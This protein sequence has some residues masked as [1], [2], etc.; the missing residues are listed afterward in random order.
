MTPSEPAIDLT[1]FPFMSEKWKAVMKWPSSHLMY[2]PI[3]FDLPDPDKDS[4][5]CLWVRLPLPQSPYLPPT[6]V[7]V[8]DFHWSIRWGIGNQGL[9]PLSYERIVEVERASP[10]SPHLTNWGPLTKV[11]RPSAEQ[12]M[13]KIPIATMTL[14]QRQLLELLAITQPVKE[15]DGDWNCQ[16]WTTSVLFRAASVEDP[17][18]QANN[19]PLLTP[20]QV[21]NVLFQARNIKHEV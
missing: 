14:K 13:A 5:V 15:P 6:P 1:A 12:E 3:S 16:N 19:G 20:E 11:V 18:V 9:L 2:P 17:I 7:R 8:E 21:N 10:V 4:E